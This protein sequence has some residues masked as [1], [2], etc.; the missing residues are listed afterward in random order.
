MT[1]K[2]VL[3]VLDD[4]E[5]LLGAVVENPDPQAIGRWHDAFKAALASAER[6]S[7]WTEVQTRARALGG[8]LDSQVGRIREAQAAVKLELERG[9]QGRRALRGYSAP[10]F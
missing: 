6:G 8:L 5:S 2:A 3:E 4:L 9:A 1:D 7:R 10:V